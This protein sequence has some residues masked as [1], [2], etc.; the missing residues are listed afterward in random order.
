[1]SRLLL[2]VIAALVACSDAFKLTPALEKC[3]EQVFKE[4]TKET[5]AAV[6]DAIHKA[7]KLVKNGSLAEAQRIVRAFG[8][9]ERDAIIK[10]YMVDDCLPLQSCFECPVEL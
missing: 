9:T 1:N 4:L 5:N 6:K 3:A 2:V 7:M 8:E 10:K